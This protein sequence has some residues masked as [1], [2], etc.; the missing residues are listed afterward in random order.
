MSGSLFIAWVKSGS[1][2][3]NL[4]FKFKEGETGA[5]E[6]IE[7]RIAIHL[8]RWLSDW[9]SAHVN[10]IIIIITI[11]IVIST[12]AFILRWRSWDIL[13]CATANAAHKNL[14]FIWT[15][16]IHAWIILGLRSI[17]A[18]V[19]GKLSNKWLN[20]SWLISIQ[21]V[22]S[23]TLKILP[24]TINKAIIAQ[25]ARKGFFKWLRACCC[26][27]YSRI[28]RACSLGN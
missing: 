17:W 5:L 7:L 26:S 20:W 13:T 23:D 15:I 25:K 10:V 22:A 14:T 4:L 21:L 1:S 8:L 9:K 19:L 2:S 11:I 16:V 12:T 6:S 18:L 28:Q 27:H 3:L 24:W